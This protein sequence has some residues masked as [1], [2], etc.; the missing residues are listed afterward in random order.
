M[1]NWQKGVK[2]GAIALA[3]FLIL[4]IISVI[5]S[6]VMIFV[7]HDYSHHHNNYVGD[8]NNNTGNVNNN[9]NYSNITNLE[10]D[11]DNATLEIKKG[12][13]FKIETYDISDN[14][15]THTTNNKLYIEEEHFW[16]WD[17]AH[18]RVT[19]YV[20]DSL[21][22]VDIDI[23]AGKLILD[24][25]QIKRLDL[26]LGSTETVLN[27]IEAL[28]SSISGG[29]GKI[30]ATNSTFNDL[31]LETGVGEVNLEGTIT[32]RSSI[33]TGVG[34]VNLNLLGGADIYQFNID[35]GLGNVNIAGEKYDGRT[36]GTGTNTIYLETGI[37]NV[38]IDFS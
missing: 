25:I 7:P 30:N 29:A 13:E 6:L 16:F 23:G 1:T 31:E 35:K 10:I 36:Y 17:K 19:I 5:F 11:L 37:G 34:K 14:F 33:E 15:K 21:D 26:D 22:N 3:I 9:V 2:Y 27:N 12:T 4:I 8:Y 24:S 38:D 20:P 28:K 32:G 18:S